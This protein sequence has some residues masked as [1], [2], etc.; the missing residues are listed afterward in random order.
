MNGRAVDGDRGGGLEAD[1]TPQDLPALVLFA[2]SARLKWLR[3]LRPGFRHC[4]VAVGLEGGWVIVDPLSHRT[5]L[6]L[7]SGVSAVQLIEWYEGQGVKALLT[8]VRRAPERLAPLA[9]ATCVEAVKRVLGIHA[10][11]I[12]TPWQLYNYVLS[13]KTKSLDIGAKS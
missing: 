9:P 12:R 4:F 10:R 7:V 2:D 8:S 3:L 6:S 1:Q 11:L 5:A 13:E